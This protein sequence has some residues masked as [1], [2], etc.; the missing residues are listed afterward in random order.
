MLTAGTLRGQGA[1]EYL[2]LLGTVLIVALVAVSLLSY[3]PSVAGDLLQQ[4][5][6][7]YWRGQAKPFT[8]AESK[9]T[10]ST[11]A[12]CGDA[13]NMNMTLV[14]KN[15]EKWRLDLDEVYVDSQAWNF[16]IYGDGSTVGNVS[17]APGEQ[18]IVTLGKPV[19]P[20]ACNGKQTCQFGI[21]FKYNSPYM[22][23][24]IQNG[25]A[26]LVVNCG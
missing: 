7:L 1:T 25:T 11:G 19:L 24:R 20:N 3:T 5:S 15:N 10:A 18:R 6:Q 17:F 2:M 14:V 23:G 12:V 4:E 16:C 8:I 26:K 22:V 13:T 21:A 9:A